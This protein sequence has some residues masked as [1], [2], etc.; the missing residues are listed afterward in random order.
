MIKTIVGSEMPFGGGSCRIE[1]SRLVYIAVQ[2]TGFCMMLSFAKG[3][4]QTDHNACSEIFLG[5]GCFHVEISRLACVV[6]RLTSFLIVWVF[7]ESFF[8]TDFSIVY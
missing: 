6:N 7:P 5:G 4:F 8:Q 2:L 3:N 1:T